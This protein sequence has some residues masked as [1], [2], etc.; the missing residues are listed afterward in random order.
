MVF[1]ATTSAARLHLAHK[2]PCSRGGTE[3]LSVCS[4]TTCGCRLCM[5]M[6]SGKSAFYRATHTYVAAAA[7]AD[8]AQTL[9]CCYRVPPDVLTLPR[10]LLLLLRLLLLFTAEFVFS[11]GETDISGASFFFYPLLGYFLRIMDP[12]VF[13][14]T[15]FPITLKPRAAESP[16]FNYTFEHLSF[17]GLLIMFAWGESNCRRRA[18]YD[19]SAKILIDAQVASRRRT[20]WII[21]CKFSC[22]YY[23]FD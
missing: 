6:R 1:F 16:F 15:V 23:T 11:F 10:A 3:Y 14:S 5:Y 8:D 22:V 7:N 12:C 13:G 2:R 4:T 19:H 17:L 20:I 18:D 21:T 9:N